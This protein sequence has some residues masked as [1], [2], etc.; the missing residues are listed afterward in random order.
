MLFL[1]NLTPHASFE[2]HSGIVRWSLDL[3]YQ[4]M[5]A[6]NNVD[7]EPES[8]TLEREPVTMA[9]APTEADFVIRDTKNPHREVATPEQFHQIREK[10]ENARPYHPG[11]G[12]TPMSERST[13]RLAKAIEF[14]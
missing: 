1:T 10:Y 13:E 9:C 3:R 4:S 12:W 11:R 7:E 14:P 5:E 2:N 8:Y 6:P